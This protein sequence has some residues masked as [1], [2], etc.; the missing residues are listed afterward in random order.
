[1]PDANFSPRSRPI[2]ANVVLHDTLNDSASV[3]PHRRPPKLRSV[4]VLCG[5]VELAQLRVRRV[6]DREPVRR[7]LGARRMRDELVLEPDPGRHDLERRT[8]REDLSP[9]PRKRRVRRGA[10]LSAWKY[11]LAACVSWLASG[12]GSNVGFEYAATI[13]AGLHVEHDDR[14]AL[15][16]E[17]VGGELLRF[18]RRASSTTLPRVSSPLKKSLRLSIVMSKSRPTSWSLY[19]ASTPVL[20]R[21]TAW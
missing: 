19:S 17:A 8:R 4:R 16:G 20:P 2:C 15:A 5:Q 18:T 1:M 21:F 7:S 10:S 12:F 13:A 9:R 6:V 11:A 3:P 14:A